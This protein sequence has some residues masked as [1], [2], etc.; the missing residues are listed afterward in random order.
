M[1]NVYGE[2]ITCHFSR[3]RVLQCQEYAP[4]TIQAKHRIALPGRFDLP[5]VAV[6]QVIVKCH[7]STWA[8]LQSRTG[9]WGAI[10]VWHAEISVDSGL[11][12]GRYV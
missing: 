8:S 10:I 3:K 5:C 4:L 9:L 2:I 7:H 1:R 12:T 6:V 11:V